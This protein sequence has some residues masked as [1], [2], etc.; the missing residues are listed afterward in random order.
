MSIFGRLSIA[1]V[2]LLAQPLP[3]GALAQDY[4]SK[5]IRI[6][7]GASPEIIPRIFAKVFTDT[8]H[9]PVIVESIPGAGG[10]LAAE[11]VARARP[12]GHTLLNATATFMIAQAQEKESGDVS[13]DFVSIAM[14]TY[15]P[16]VL[17]VNTTLPVRS[18]QELIALAKTKP[19]KLNYGGSAGFP[20]FAFELFKRMA[21][22]DIVYVPYKRSDDV[23]QAMLSGQ[24]DAA[25]S[26]YTQAA[27]ISR[28]GKVRTLA[29]APAQRSKTLPDVPTLSESGLPGYDLLGW[30][31]FVAPLGTPAAVVAKLNAIVRQALA[32]PDVLL[33]IAKVNQEPGS[34][35]SPEQYSE[36]LRNEKAKWTRLVTEIGF[37]L[38]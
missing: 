22:V 35:F 37:K 6:V 5:P 4:P 20:H 15:T 13:K 9:Q 3:N 16:F 23:A 36:F 18:V 30:N 12:D 2:L 38:E 1:I 21:K 26:P 10:K 8:L 27:G 19:G 14:T 31:G 33:L 28:S 25:F 11:A 34:D 24:I 17:L 7:N 29:V 32:Q